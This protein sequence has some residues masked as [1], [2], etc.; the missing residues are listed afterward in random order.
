MPILRLND[1]GLPEEMG[2]EGDAPK[3]PQMVESDD[4]LKMSIIEDPQTLKDKQAVKKL[5]IM[6]HMRQVENYTKNKLKN[7]AEQKK[8]QNMAEKAHLKN[9]ELRAFLN[10]NKNKRVIQALSQQ[11]QMY[12]NLS[13]VSGFGLTSDGRRPYLDR[14]AV[15]WT[16]QLYAPVAFGTK[17]EAWDN[18]M[19]QM[20]TEVYSPPV[21]TGTKSQLVSM[22]S[23]VASPP[24]YKG[25]T[26]ISI[27]DPGPLTEEDLNIIKQFENNE[28]KAPYGRIDLPYARGMRTWGDTEKISTVTKNSKYNSSV[29]FLDRKKA[30]WMYSG[31]YDDNGNWVQVKVPFIKGL[32]MDWPDN[33]DQKKR[34]EYRNLSYFSNYDLYFFTK[35]KPVILAYARKLKYDEQLKKE[36][37]DRLEKEIL[38]EASRAADEDAFKASQVVEAAAQQKALQTMEM[39]I[40][41]LRREDAIGKEI[42]KPQKNYAHPMLSYGLVPKKDKAAKITASQT[43]A[44]VI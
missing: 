31:F 27:V 24:V 16:P 21:I 5:Q 8:A 33:P 32:P 20:E 39:G 11:G 17:G 42:P 41:K 44:G 34:D 19:G 2:R 12:E 40:D 18:G 36:T 28:W 15:D 4:V 23:I 1:Q 30:G 6:D 26:T 35:L 7:I 3:A 10:T 37:A 13:G 38:A 22:P 43:K 29:Y 14:P 25:L 9:K